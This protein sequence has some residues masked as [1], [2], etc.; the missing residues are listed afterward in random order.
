MVAVFFWIDDSFPYDYETKYKEDQKKK[1]KRKWT[2]I[3]FT[4]FTSVL[5]LTLC[6]YLTVCS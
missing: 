4:P 1:E 3:I 6:R 5:F 2:S